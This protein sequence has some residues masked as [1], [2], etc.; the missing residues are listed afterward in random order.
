MKKTIFFAVFI[1]SLLCTANAQAQQPRSG[2]WRATTGFGVLEFNVNATGTLIDTVFLWFANWTCGPVTMVSGGIKTYWPGSGLPITNREFQTSR[3]INIGTNQTMSISG[4]FNQTGDKASGTWSSNTYGTTCSGNW[5]ALTVSVEEILQPDQFHIA[6]NYPNPFNP[7]TTIRFSIPHE[8][9]V[10]LKVYNMLGSEVATLVN[11][12]LSA[13]DHSVD[14]N[15]TGLSSGT[16]Y[17][18]L[19]AGN[20]VETKKMNL[21]K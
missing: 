9:F 19:I 8:V 14:F 20:F 5:D 13:G 15:A 3:G 1:L 6:Q 10:T 16:Y 12:N 18:R 4:T 21:L 7:T 11:E 17:Y 2:K